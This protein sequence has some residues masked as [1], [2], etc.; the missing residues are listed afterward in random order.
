MVDPKKAPPGHATPEQ[1]DHDQACILSEL[2]GT[3]GGIDSFP[4]AVRA[5]VGSPT[6]C[7]GRIDNLYSSFNRRHASV[8]RPSAM[9]AILSIE[10]LRSDR[11][12]PP[13]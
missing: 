6:T 2:A 5:T 1:L 13:I 3:D 4:E 10:T 9:R 7:R 12:I 11:S 8:P